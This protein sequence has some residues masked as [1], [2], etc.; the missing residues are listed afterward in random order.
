MPSPDPARAIRDGLASWWSLKSYPADNLT[1]HVDDDF[2]PAANAPAL[3]IA[4]DGDATPQNLRQAWL[5]RKL[6]RRITIRITAF[7]VGRTQARELVD[8]AVDEIVA[9]KPAQ[10]ARIEDV[11]A[12]LVTRDRD[13]GAWLASVTVPVTVKPQ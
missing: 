1:L 3:L 10:I 5:L 13:T 7:A 4:D 2:Q 12:P 6:P 9:N 11:P 8:E